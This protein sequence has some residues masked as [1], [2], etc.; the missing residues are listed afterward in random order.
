MPY[1]SQI[2]A[3]AVLRQ[4]VQL[5]E[6]DGIEQLSMSK[7][8]GALDVTAASLYRYFRNKAALLRAV[9]SDTTRRLFAALDDAPRHASPAE[10]LLA[11][12][13][14]YRTFAHANPATYGMLFTNTIDDLRPDPDENVR[15]VLPYQQIMAQLTGDAKSLAALRGFLALV[16]GFV[17]LEL[18]QQLR[19][20]GDLDA[21]F[22]QSVEAY[23]AG[24]ATIA[25]S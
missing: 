19:R 6:S 16:H 5:I 11:I 2:N 17:M 23:V 3:D 13:Q 1:P 25:L 15:F 14:A 12:A 20:G 18:A 9:N 22:R 24:W 8:A 10:T 21:A 7:L 4:A